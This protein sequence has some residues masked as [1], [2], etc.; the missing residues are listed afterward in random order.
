MTFYLAYNEKC[1]FYLLA[2]NGGA[3]EAASVP[4]K[5]SQCFRE[6]FPQYKSMGDLNCHG[7]QSSNPIINENLMQPFPFPD[8]A[9]H[10]K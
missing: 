7:N 2:T 9:A 1:A 10:D 4:K 6:V 8:N 3:G 5:H